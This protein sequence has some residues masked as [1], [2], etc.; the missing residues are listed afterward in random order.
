VGEDFPD[1]GL[2]VEDPGGSIELL[3]HRAEDRAVFRH[4]V[5]LSKDVMIAVR[6][7]RSS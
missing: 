5:V 6:P 2:E 1:S 4:V 7:N 3:E